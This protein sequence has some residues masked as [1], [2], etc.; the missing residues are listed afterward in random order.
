MST[1]V[2]RSLYLCRDS[3][4][5]SAVVFRHIRAVFAL[6]FF[7]RIMNFRPDQKERQLKI[8]P[9]PLCIASTLLFDL[10]S[11]SFMLQY[12]FVIKKLKYIRT[13]ISNLRSVWA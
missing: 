1:T 11:A 8:L 9:L 12:F 10:G 2:S 13:T 5:S 4:V 3:I 7:A 6:S